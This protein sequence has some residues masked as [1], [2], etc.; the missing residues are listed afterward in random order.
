MPER[1][2]FVSLHCAIPTWNWCHVLL[3]HACFLLA[4]WPAHAQRTYMRTCD[5]EYVMDGKCAYTLLLPLN[6]GKRWVFSSNLQI[7][8]GNS[9]QHSK[10]E[11]GKKSPLPPKMY[12][13]Q[14]CVLCGFSRYYV[15]HPSCCFAE[16][17]PEDTCPDHVY[18]SVEGAAPSGGQ[19]AQLESLA[20]NITTLHT[21]MLEQSHMLNQLQSVLL[22]LSQN[23]GWNQGLN[24]TLSR[25]NQT[26]TSG[27]TP[28]QL[29]T[30][31]TA[32]EMLKEEVRVLG[33][34]AVGLERE[35]NGFKESV[36]HL[37]EEVQF[38]NEKTKSFQTFMDATTPLVA[39]LQTE[40]NGY[41]EAGFFCR[42]KGEFLH[43]PWSGV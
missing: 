31:Q 16:A 25:L 41:K 14:Q 1:K 17:L 20:L 33:S 2:L 5:C 9:A 13:A 37:S 29:H 7:I 24:E 8:K 6:K 3:V 36:S 10:S 30:V 23:G 42:R 26:Q 18:P 40:L 21:R 11:R 43:H 34:D 39:A 12:S 27:V 32:V 15:S 28:A 38:L 22:S 35:L 4:T 19:T